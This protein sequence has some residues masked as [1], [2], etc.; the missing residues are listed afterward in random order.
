M[1]ILRKEEF[2]RSTRGHIGGYTLARPAHEIS[3]SSVLEALGGKLYDDEF[4]GRY[5]G[6]LPI[7]THAV[8]CS[9]RSIWQIIQ[10]AVDKALL[11]ITLAQMMETK[12]NV[13]LFD[14]PRRA[15]EVS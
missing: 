1:S 4:C 9:V 12:S 6:H 7:C 10:D 13:T 3:V 8:D 2:V 11:D 15:V 14:A 5:A